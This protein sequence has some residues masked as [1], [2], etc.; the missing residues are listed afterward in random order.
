MERKVSILFFALLICFSCGRVDEYD[1]EEMQCER[2]ESYLIDNDID[3]TMRNNVY[4]QVLNEVTNISTTRLEKGDSLYLYYAGYAFDDEI[5]DLY[6]TN[7]EDIALSQSVAFTGDFE[8]L[9]IVYGESDIIDGLY[10]GL[11]SA[12]QGDS[13]M[14]YMPSTMAYGDKI[15]GV[16]S[17]YT[18]IAMMVSVYKVVK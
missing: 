13:L 9:K 18:P 14:L 6:T 15:C 12:L 3:F 5:G 17:K 16:L 2:I 11:D 4:K 10:V 7:M 8:P 1:T